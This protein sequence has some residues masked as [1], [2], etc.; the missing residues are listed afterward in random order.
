MCWGRHAVQTG[1]LGR[2]GRRCQPCM[3]LAAHSN[4]WCACLLMQ[5]LHSHNGFGLLQASA[6]AGWHGSHGSAQL[7]AE[8]Q[9]GEATA[10]APVQRSIT[11]SPVT[12]DMRV[13]HTLVQQHAGEPAAWEMC[14][15]QQQL[16]PGHNSV[17]PIFVQLTAGPV[18]LHMPRVLKGGLKLRGHRRSIRRHAWKQGSCPMYATVP[19]SVLISAAGALHVQ[20]GKTAVACLLSCLHAA[21]RCSPQK[22][23]RDAGRAA[24]YPAPQKGSW[25]LHR[26]STGVAATRVRAATSSCIKERETD[27]TAALHAP[28]LPSLPNCHLHRPTS[29]H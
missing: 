15:E 24:A 2:A 19:L 11:C 14:G 21:S 25:T 1:R 9:A 18:T 27:S 10:D 22:P 3:G 12:D 29:C 8:Q 13:Y 5:G 17:V 6:Q 26:P 23:C 16:R 28:D 7:S 20:V 4:Q